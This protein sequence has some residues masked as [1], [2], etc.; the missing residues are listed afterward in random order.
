MS[1][2]TI[3][4]MKLLIKLHA[5]CKREIKLY[6][7]GSCKCLNLFFLPSLIYTFQSCASIP[8]NRKHF[9]QLFIPDENHYHKCT[10]I[11]TSFF[12]PL[13]IQIPQQWLILQLINIYHQKLNQIGYQ[14]ITRVNIALGLMQ[15]I[16]LPFTIKITKIN[17]KKI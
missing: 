4:M 5:L 8:L 12:V 2:F 6:S 11:Q 15:N 10:F 14:Y 9:S 13:Y 16:F 7:S 1:K 17:T 3:T